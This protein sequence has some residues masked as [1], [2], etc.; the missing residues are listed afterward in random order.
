M[1]LALYTQQ[2]QPC[3]ELRHRTS[4]FQNARATVHSSKELSCTIRKAMQR[5]HLT[6]DGLRQSL[7][8]SGAMVDKILSGDV[9]PSHHLERQ[10]VELLGISEQRVRRVTRMRWAAANGD[11]DRAVRTRKA[12]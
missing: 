11:P 10:M 2:W 8:V 1:N 12:A 3:V 6:P 5:K 7:G 9:V 4:Q